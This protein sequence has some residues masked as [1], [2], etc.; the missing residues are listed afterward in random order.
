M[1]TKIIVAKKLLALAKELVASH[2]CYEQVFPESAT[3]KEMR[4]AID[5]SMMNEYDPLES[6]HG[7]ESNLVLFNNVFDTKEEARRFLDRYA[8]RWQDCAC[9]FRSVMDTT[10][11]KQAYYQRYLE[12]CKKAENAIVKILHKTD[13]TCPKCGSQYPSWL[14]NDGSR[15]IQFYLSEDSVHPVMDIIPVKCCKCFSTIIDLREDPAVKPII[16]KK[17][18]LDEECDKMAGDS[19]KTLMWLVRADRHV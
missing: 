16:R 13:L 5:Q 6:S 2:S 19:E 1:N 15:H 18:K 8:D 12:L 9:K 7:M 4:D 10:A 17:Q 3:L 11:I 14:L